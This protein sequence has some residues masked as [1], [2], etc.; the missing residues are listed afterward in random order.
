MLFILTF[1]G[2]LQVYMQSVDTVQLLCAML[3]FA[4]FED[5]VRL[6]EVQF[7]FT[8]HVV[9]EPAQPPVGKAE[10]SGTTY[11]KT[12]SLPVKTI[13]SRH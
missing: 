11:S 1:L 5:V 7:C 4:F 10:D 8:L 12:I 9:L 13:I 3:T 2:K 6:S